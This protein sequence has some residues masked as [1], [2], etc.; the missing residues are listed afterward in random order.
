MRIKS[1]AASGPEAASAANEAQ[2]R[3]RRWLWAPVVVGA[4]LGLFA[5]LNALAP[6]PPAPFSTAAITVSLFAGEPGGGAPAGVPL[7]TPEAVVTDAEPTPVEPAPEPDPP[8][9]PPPPPQPSPEAPPPEPP[10]PEPAAPPALA[11]DD[12]VAAV[13]AILGDAAAQAED[14]AATPGPELGV[15]PGGGNKCEAAGAI[16]QELQSDEKALGALER[17]PRESLSVAQAVQL[18]NGVWVDEADLG[19]KGVTLPIREALVRAV[20]NAP[21][22]LDTPFAGPRFLVVQVESGPIVVVIGSGEWR[23]REL[24]ATSGV[25][26]AL[27]TKPVPR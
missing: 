8:P 6:D 19:G 15:G 12:V 24:V 3:R 26:V 17:L 20:L 16:L 14:A 11:P 27:P 9:E 2:R 5:L 18:W 7:Q 10:P 4:H 13:R 21:D 23:W 25:Y 1:A 22:C